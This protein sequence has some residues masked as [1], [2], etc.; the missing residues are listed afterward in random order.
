[1]SSN[2]VI[3]KRTSAMT[4]T[5]RNRFRR[6]IRTL[7]DAPGDPNPYGRMVDHHADMS[8]NMHGMNSVGEQRF[9]PWHRVYLLKL[10]RMGRQIDDQFFIPYWDWTAQ[11]SIPTWIASYNPTVKVEGTDVVVR[12]NPGS[13]TQLPTAS[14]VNSILN[15]TTFTSFT[16]DLERG[17]HNFVHGWVNGTMSFINIAP[18]DPL[19]WMHHAQIDRLWSIWQS[20]NPNRNPTLNGANRRM[21][22]WNE[23]EAQVRSISSLGYSYGP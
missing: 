3:R 14:Q 13:S 21:D 11:R 22:P 17:P 5:E 12:R 2:I 18:A 8:H 10:E 23:T 16:R 6:V 4:V 1:M 7:I 19:F 9:L 15:R 20:N